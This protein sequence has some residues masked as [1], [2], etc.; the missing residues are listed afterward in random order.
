MQ[1]SSRMSGSSAGERNGFNQYA[2]AQD[3]T[4]TLGFHQP[5]V[6]LRWPCH[7]MRRYGP[8][9]VTSSSSG[10]ARLSA[11]RSGRVRGLT[12]PEGVPDKL[13]GPR[14]SSHHWER[15]GGHAAI[16]VLIN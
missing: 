12:D 4:I 14:A 9:W 6:R 2:Q 8:S 11:S 10:T 3:V 5:T 16:F 7:R 15:A 13:S 1:S